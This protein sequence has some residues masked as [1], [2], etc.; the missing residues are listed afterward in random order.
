[1]K[2]YKSISK[3]QREELNGLIKNTNRFSFSEKGLA[4]DR[5]SGQFVGIR[6][7]NNASLGSKVNVISRFNQHA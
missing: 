6:P 1:M 4:F 5:K 2:N 7:I 3:E